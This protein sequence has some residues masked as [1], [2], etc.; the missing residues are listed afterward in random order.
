M[1]PA[2]AKLVLATG[3]N[4]FIILDGHLKHFVVK[5]LLVWKFL[6]DFSELSAATIY[7]L[8]VLLPSCIPVR[9]QTWQIA[10]DQ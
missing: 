2:F 10:N 7:F 6:P 3:E 1:K 4:Q 8:S 9:E 5:I